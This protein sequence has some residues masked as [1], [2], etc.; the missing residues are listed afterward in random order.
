MIIDFTLRYLTRLVPGL[1]VATLFILLLPRRLIQ[2]RIFAY[3]LA[4]ILIRDTI[5]PLGLWWF[6]A[7]WEPWLRMK[8]EPALVMVL[9]T[10]AFGVALLMNVLEPD[11]RRLVVWWRG[12][13]L[14]ALLG[15]LCGALLVFVPFIGITWSTPIAERGGAVDPSSWLP[16]ALMCLLIN[17]YEET[18]FRG[19][20]QGYLETQVS[21][22]RAALLSGTAFAFGHLFLAITVT[23]TPWLVG[24]T[25]YEGLVAAFVRMRFGMVASVLAHGLGIFPLVAGVF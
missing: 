8:S 6:G 3:I 13:K 15:G 17:F 22:P 11:L 12:G 25:L 14:A 10:V 24:F 1:L 9:G 19:Y 7:G 18:L 2:M 4:F 5:T 20:L 23:N 16:L 21:W